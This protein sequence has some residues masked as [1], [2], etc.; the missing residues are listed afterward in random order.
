MYDAPSLIRLLERH[1]FREAMTLPTG[2]TTITD[3][4]E[5]NLREREEES[6]YVEAVRA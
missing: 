3:P 6:L 1:G 2:E 5:L 4:G